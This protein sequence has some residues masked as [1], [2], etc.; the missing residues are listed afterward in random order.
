ML[1]SPAGVARREELL[2]QEFGHKVFAFAVADGIVSHLDSTERGMALFFCTHLLAH[3][4][5]ARGAT[6][7]ASVAG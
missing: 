3:L 7:F 4:S 1:F 2:Q 6:P 5:A